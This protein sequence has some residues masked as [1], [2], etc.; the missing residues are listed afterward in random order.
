LVWNIVS[1]QTNNR[2]LIGDGVGSVEANYGKWQ[3]AYFTNN[4]G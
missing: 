2:F 3:A 4:G 1:G